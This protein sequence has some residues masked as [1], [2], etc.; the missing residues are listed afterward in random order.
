MIWYEF[1]RVAVNRMTHPLNG[2][3]MGHL[4]KLSSWKQTQI[5]L[6][7]KGVDLKKLQRTAIWICLAQKWSRMIGLHSYLVFRSQAY[8]AATNFLIFLSWFNMALTLSTTN[9]I[10][11]QA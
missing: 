5:Q 11:K 9:I 7:C 8:A 2:H 3:S 6:S 10:W 4:Q 1:S